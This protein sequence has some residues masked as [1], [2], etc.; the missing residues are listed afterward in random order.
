MKLVNAELFLNIDIE[1]NTPTVLAIENPKVLTSVVSQLYG[2]CNSGE[3]DFIL[4]EDGKQLSIERTAEIIINPFQIDFNSRKIQSKLYSEL[5][6]AEV[7]YSEDKALIQTLII[8]YL[9]KL[10]QN[11][12]YEMITNELDMDSMKLL[13]MFEVRIEPQCN[14]LLEK[15][16]EYTKLLARLLKKGLLVFINISNYLGT[17]ELNA[18]FEICNYNKIKVLLIEHYELCLPFH[19]KTYIIDKD[20]CM[21]MK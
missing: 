8:E 21:I 14:S 2:M 1:E 6:D 4:S 11:V 12:P 19:V 5:L 17:E 9:D 15:L 10:T 16:V 18:L 13:K 7:F 20:K 3:G